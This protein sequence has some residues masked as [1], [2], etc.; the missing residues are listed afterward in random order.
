METRT[1][2]LLVLA[3]LVHSIWNLLSKKSLD[4]QAFLWLSLVAMS[5]LF[6]PLLLHLYTPISSRGWAYVIPSGAV[7]AMYFLL[8]GS[9]YQ[10][11]D[12][13]LVYAVA[14]GTAP[15]FVVLIARGFLGEHI[16]LIGFTGILLIVVGIYSMHLK[17]L[18]LTGLYAPLLSLGEG[19][20][21]I[22]FLTGLTIA[23]YSVVDKVGISYVHPLQYAYL[24]LSVATVLLAP[25]MIF[26]RSGSLIREWKGNR[27][28]AIAVAVMFITAYLLV[29]LAMSTSRVSYVSSVRE[30]SVVIATLLGTFVLHERLG[31][32]RFLGSVLIFAGIVCIGLRG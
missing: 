16:S 10:R 27:W 7:E 6:F 29:L 17:S 32:R 4:T 3:G 31:E 14:R 12:F 18:D 30:V 21:R 24:V 11:A 28:R 22:A 5:I 13:S 23:S 26:A 2:L 1:I 15:L 19:P 25:Y 9:A 20:S 8:L